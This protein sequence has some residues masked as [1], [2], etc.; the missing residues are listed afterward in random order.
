MQK[1]SNIDKIIEDAFEALIAA[2]YLDQ[3]MEICQKIVKKIFLLVDEN[4]I[5]PLTYDYKSFIQNKFINW[6]KVG[7]VKYL[8]KRLP[9]NL[10]RSSLWFNQIK[11]GE[12]FG[13]NKKT[14]EKQAAKSAYTKF[15]NWN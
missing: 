3:N 10:Y 11:Y 12:G 1:L 4:T 5:S 7:K 9:N 8:T 6:N 14:A 15:V 13:M 2:I